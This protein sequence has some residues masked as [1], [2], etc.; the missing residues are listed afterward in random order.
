MATN[1]ELSKT[2]LKTSLRAIHLTFLLETHF[3][4]HL[5]PQEGR[6]NAGEDASY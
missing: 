3:C 1:N 6:Q 5:G 2:Y 4:Y